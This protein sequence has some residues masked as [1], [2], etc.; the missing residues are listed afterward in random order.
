MIEYSIRLQF[1]ITPHFFN[2]NFYDLLKKQGYFILLLS[3][4]SKMFQVSILTGRLTTQLD[5][6]LEKCS[7]GDGVCYQ[8]SQVCANSNLINSSLFAQHSVAVLSPDKG[9]ITLL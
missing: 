2:I 3:K 4:I 7:D 8:M 1:K 5:P 9:E 6:N